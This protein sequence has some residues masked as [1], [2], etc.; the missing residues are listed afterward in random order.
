MHHK[1]ALHSEFM[2][3][4]VCTPGYKTN[5]YL[6]CQYTY[7][8]KVCVSGTPDDIPTFPTLLIS[9]KYIL[10]CQKLLTLF[11]PVFVNVEELFTSVGEDITQT[12]PCNIQLFF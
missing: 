12:C 3:V 2:A 1:L 11:P 5:A 9:L 4:L 6:I 10:L 8:F 7:G